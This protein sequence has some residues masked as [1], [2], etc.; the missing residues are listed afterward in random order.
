MMRYC[1]ERERRNLR[2][3]RRAAYLARPPVVGLREHAV[4]D[5]L[6]NFGRD[7]R[8]HVSYVLQR[9]VAAA[10]GV[11]CGKHLPRFCPRVLLQQGA[12]SLHKLL[13]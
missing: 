10:V 5:M 11:E 9:Q 12:D 7:G 6:R 8:E 1:S 4:N 3:G 13:S 2:R